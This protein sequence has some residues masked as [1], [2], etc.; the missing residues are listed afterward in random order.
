MLIEWMKKWN[1]LEAFRVAPKWWPSELLPL[2]PQLFL[3]PNLVR[4]S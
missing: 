3:P 4:S 1:E 2:G